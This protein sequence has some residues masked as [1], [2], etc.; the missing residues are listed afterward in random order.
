MNSDTQIGMHCSMAQNLKLAERNLKTNFS[1]SQTNL[2]KNALLRQ[3]VK[4]HGLTQNAMM[5]GARKYDFIKI[6]I[7]ATQLK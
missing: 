7:K 4:I 5:H 3:M 2:L 6:D 1:I